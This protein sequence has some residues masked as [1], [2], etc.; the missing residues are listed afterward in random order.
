[1]TEPG[2]CTPDCHEDHDH[3]GDC[4]ECGKRRALSHFPE[5]G[6]DFCAECYTRLEK[7]YLGPHF[8]DRPEE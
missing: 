2:S 1:M 5:L 3:V 6:G 8:D 4:A 7:D